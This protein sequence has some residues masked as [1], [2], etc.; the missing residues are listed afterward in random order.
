MTKLQTLTDDAPLDL[1]NENVVKMVIDANVD[2]QKRE[3]K[4]NIHIQ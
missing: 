1:S 3:H 4:Q 2:N